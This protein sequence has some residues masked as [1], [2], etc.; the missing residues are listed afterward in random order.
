MLDCCIPRIVIMAQ[1]YQLR[2]THTAL[3]HLYSRAFNAE[4]P[5]TENVEPA[6]GLVATTTQSYLM[7]LSKI[8][9]RVFGAYLNVK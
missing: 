5:T 4:T 8:G 3:E 7:R 2:P 9:G 1:A 6:V